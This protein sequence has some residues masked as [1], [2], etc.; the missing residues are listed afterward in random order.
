M[1]IYEKFKIRKN[2]ISVNFFPETK[3]EL[4]DI[5]TDKVDKCKAAGNDT[6]DL[7]DI[8]ISN[9]TNLS[10]LFHKI[11]N[12]RNDSFLKTNI[13]TINVT[14]WDT[15]NVNDMQF[16]FRGIDGIKSIIGL[17]TWDTSNVTSFREFFCHC[18][19]LESVDGIKN[20]K[21]DKCTDI[22]YMFAHCKSLSQ[23][24]LSVVENWHIPYGQ[25]ISG[26]FIDC[27]LLENIDL[28]NW[29]CSKIYTC[30][31]M[32]KKCILLNTIKGIDEWDMKGC[33]DIGSMFY[34]CKSLTTVGDLSK[35]NT[36]SFLDVEYLFFDCYKLK[37]DCSSWKLPKQSKT[38]YAFKGTQQKNIIKFKK[39]V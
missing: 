5:I 33:T 3:D 38:V 16:M 9:I 27:E 34:G 10:T 29:N 35:W 2:K 26:V 22:A 14:G 19:L 30:H 6:L 37:V 25:W 32:F 20:F 1:K 28:S 36:Y 11:A 21:F 17:G 8:D 18:S 39:P 4:I 13:K 12:S 15:S 23:S 7:S 31:S 24:Q